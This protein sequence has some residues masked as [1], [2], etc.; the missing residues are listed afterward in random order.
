MANHTKA[1]GSLF[2]I[3]NRLACLPRPA[4]RYWFGVAMASRETPWIACHVWC[5]WAGS[6]GVCCAALLFCNIFL[7]MKQGCP[8]SL[9]EEA[10]HLSTFVSDVSGRLAFAFELEASEWLAWE[11]RSIQAGMHSKKS[12]RWKRKDDHQRQLRYNSSRAE[13]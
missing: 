3:A 10:G 12:T 8:H 5:D 6:A 9:L 4:S 2:R 7:D 1:C 13:I 11:A